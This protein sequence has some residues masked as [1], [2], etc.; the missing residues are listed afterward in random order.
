M[1][2]TQLDVEYLFTLNAS[3]AQGRRG[4]I[5]GGPTGSRYIAEVTGGDFA[6]PRLSGTVALPA[7]DWVHLRDDRSMH[8][9]VRVLLVTDDGES[10]LMTYNGIGVPDEDGVN[11]I[12]TAPR[13]ETGAEAY[14]WLNNVQA[15]GIGRSVEGGVTYEVYALT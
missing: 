13:F 6:G 1:A 7:G 10:I 15:V 5:P 14:A 11:Q 2:T 12:R 8:L 4:L 9:D 3:V